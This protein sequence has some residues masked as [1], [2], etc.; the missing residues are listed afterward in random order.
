[1]IARGFY[2]DATSDGGM[3]F[4]LTERGHA[5]AADDELAIWPPIA[6]G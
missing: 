1:M 6:G 2:R 3:G 5:L 4:S